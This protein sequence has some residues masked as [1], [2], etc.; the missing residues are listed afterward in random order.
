MKVLA[1]NGSSRKDG[2]TADMLNLVLAEIEKEGHEIE[3]IQLAGHTINPCKACFACAGKS[4]CVF[5]ND[6]FRELYTKMTEADA[7]VLGSSTYSADV[8]STLKAVIERASVVSDTNP[9][10]FRHKVAGAVAV[11][12]RAGAMNT[13]DTINHFFLNKEMY[14]VGSTYW[15]IAYGRLPGEALKDEEGVANMKNLGENIAWLLN[16]L[17]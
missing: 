6:I 12:R 2:N 17:K 10:M 8:S 5:D 11:A 13:I 4:N 14:L 3:L 9:G 16:H 7:I 15:N 1:I